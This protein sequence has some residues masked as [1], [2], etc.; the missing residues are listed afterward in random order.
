[1]KENRSSLTVS[2]GK[3][4]VTFIS[5]FSVT[6]QRKFFVSSLLAVAALSSKQCELLGK[7]I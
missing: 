4:L 7:L 2:R 6:S 5:P 1:M 3:A